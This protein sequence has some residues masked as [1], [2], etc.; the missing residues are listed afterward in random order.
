VIVQLSYMRRQNPVLDRTLVGGV[1]KWRLKEGAH[2]NGETP[3]RLSDRADAVAPIAARSH[4]SG[5]TDAEGVR[6]MRE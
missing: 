3:A 1:Y 5:G 2:G 4:G 6:E